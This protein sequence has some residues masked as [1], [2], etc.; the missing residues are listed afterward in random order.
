M[1]LT[2]RLDKDNIGQERVWCVSVRE[3]AEF[4]KV[5]QSFTNSTWLPNSAM[6]MDLKASRTAT[7]FRMF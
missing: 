2:N 3:I 7:S 1:T 4:C 6:Y 5:Q